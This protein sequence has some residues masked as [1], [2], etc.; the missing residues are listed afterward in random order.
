MIMKRQHIGG[1]NTASDLR[2]KPA[3]IG[4]PAPSAMYGS[5]KS[6]RAPALETSLLDWTMVT[7]DGEGAGTRAF[8]GVRGFGRVDAAYRTLFFARQGERVVA[9]S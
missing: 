4:I 2:K 5:I 1:K 3:E 7:E 8:E 6:F 9:V